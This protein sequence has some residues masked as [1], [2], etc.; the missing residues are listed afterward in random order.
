[1]AFDGWLFRQAPKKAWFKI[2]HDLNFCFFKL[3][4]LVRR[5]G[6]AS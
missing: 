4:K 3:V 1:M 5:A 2:Q 6:N